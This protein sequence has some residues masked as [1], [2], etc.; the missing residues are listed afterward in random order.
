MI[1]ETFWGWR[2]GE[3]SPELLVAWDEYT[4]D[5]YPEG[6]EAAVEEALKGAGDEMV[7]VRRIQ[8][9]VNY[10]QITSQ[11]EVPTLHAKVVKEES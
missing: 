4:V 9:S 1:I 3:D 6:Y 7:E 11:F 8:L 2:K 5:G 10:T